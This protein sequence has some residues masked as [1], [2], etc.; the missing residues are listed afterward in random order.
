MARIRV[1][2]DQKIPR[3]IASMRRAGCIK[4]GTGC[5]GASASAVR[6]SESR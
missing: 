2:Y 3:M 5:I 4:K 6:L 1:S